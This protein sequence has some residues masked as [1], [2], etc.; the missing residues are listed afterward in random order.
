[1]IARVWK[2]W[3][4]RDNANAYETLL[5]EEIFPGFTK[6]DGYC[7]STI[8]RGEEHQEEIEFMITSFFNSLDAIKAFAGQDDYDIAVIEPEAEALLSRGDS[9]AKHYELR[10]A[11]QLE[12]FE[13]KNR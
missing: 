9:H 7:G 11:F 2:G 10:E 5:R 13:E 12:A 4:S 8:Y 1:M 3:T 6:I